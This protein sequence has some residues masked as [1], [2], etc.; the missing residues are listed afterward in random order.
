MNLRISGLL[1][2]AAFALVGLLGSAQSL[3]QNAY[4]TNEGSKTVSVINTATDKVTANIPVV[5]YTYGV[6]VAPDGGN[7][8][9]TNG[10]S[11]DTNTVSVIDPATNTV[12]TTI[13]VD[14]QPKGLAVTPDGGRVYVANTAANTVSVIATSTNTVVTTTENQY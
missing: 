10:L 8:Y 5:L 4:I 9:V 11:S 7:V 6:A 3:A 13:T 1:A 14:A 2:I 12:V